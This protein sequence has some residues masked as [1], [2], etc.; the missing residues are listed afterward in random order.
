MDRSAVDF[1]SALADGMDKEALLSAETLQALNA[2]QDP[3]ALSSL[4]QQAADVPQDTPPEESAEPVA[5]E[6]SQEP[7]AEEEPVELAPNPD[8]PRQEVYE[9]DVPKGMFTNDDVHPL[10]LVFALKASYGDDWATWLPE[11][12]WSIDRS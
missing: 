1:F 5:E 9:F 12:L 3:E 11:T 10:V 7:I 6:E 8:A 2:P 4:E